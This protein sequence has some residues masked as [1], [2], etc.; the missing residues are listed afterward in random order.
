LLEHRH[1]PAPARLGQ[2]YLQVELREAIIAY[3][4]Q[5]GLEGLRSLL[6]WFGEMLNAAAPLRNDSNYEALLIAHEYGH[7][8]MTG[9][10]ERLARAMSHGSLSSLPFLGE[11]FSA[12]VAHDRDLGP[13]RDAY[14]AFLYDYLQ[15]RLLDAVGRKLR[16]LPQLVG[17]L[18]QLCDTIQPMPRPADYSRIEDLVSLGVFGPKAQ[19]MWDFESKIETL[20]AATRGS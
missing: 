12:F 3:F 5:D 10:F 7:V 11:A 8:L 14:R 20:E 17:R 2:P 13:D 6:D 9:A 18:R 1:I 15:R 19:L 16:D 4:E